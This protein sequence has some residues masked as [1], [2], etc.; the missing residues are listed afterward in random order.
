MD[1]NLG[2]NQSPQ[3]VE[4][5]GVLGLPGTEITVNQPLTKTEVQQQ[6]AS[7][8]EGAIETQ[9]ADQAQPEV[10]TPVS[11]SAKKAPITPA[12]Q[13]PESPQQD[14]DI[15]A[16]EWTEVSDQEIKQASKGTPND[17]RRWYGLHLGWKR[18]RE[19][20]KNQ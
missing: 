13:L 6:G 1:Q 7:Q 14:G 15:F 17:T 10:S 20:G 12:G 2:S 16:K 3:N 19:G 8:Q 4:T 5:D 11:T 18:M 9:T